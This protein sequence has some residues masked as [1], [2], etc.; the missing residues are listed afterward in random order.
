M[1]AIVGAVDEGKLKAMMRGYTVNFGC[2]QKGWVGGSSPNDENVFKL[3]GALRGIGVHDSN[4]FE[5]RKFSA[6]R[7]KLFDLQV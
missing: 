2:V 6:N 3:A 7:Q 4:T 5:I 1:S